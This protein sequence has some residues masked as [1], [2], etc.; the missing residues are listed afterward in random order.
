MF[1][2]GVTIFQAIS[3]SLFQYEGGVASNDIR[4]IS[5]LVTTGSELYIFVTV[6][7]NRFLFSNQPDALIV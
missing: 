5:D 3:F 1:V 4:S 7:R 2:D 6:H